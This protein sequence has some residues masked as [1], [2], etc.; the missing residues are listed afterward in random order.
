MAATQHVT[1]TELLEVQGDAISEINGWSLLCQS[2]VTL[3]ESK[4]MMVATQ[5]SPQYSLAASV[6]RRIKAI[7]C[8]REITDNNYTSGIS[9]R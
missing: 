7:D 3:L 6:P 5:Y 8:Q 1:L 2:T 9:F 4:S